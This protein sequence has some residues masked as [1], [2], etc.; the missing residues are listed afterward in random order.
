MT[1]PAQGAVYRSVLLAGVASAYP[2]SLGLSE[3]LDGM[4]KGFAFRELPGGLCSEIE[5]AP[6]S[7]HQGHARPRGD[8]SGWTA[9]LRRDDAHVTHN[10][11]TPPG[12]RNSQILVCKIAISLRNMHIHLVL[13][14]GR[15]GGHEPT[16]ELWCA[17]RGPG[18]PY[19]ESVGTSAASE[20]SRR[21]QSCR[22]PVL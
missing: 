15:T 22:S 4:H 17:R 1:R 19:A 3:D 18:S 13:L 12:L 21:M 10:I 16:A 6:R 14:P 7:T 8:R 2:C 11:D 20:P 5:S 9:R